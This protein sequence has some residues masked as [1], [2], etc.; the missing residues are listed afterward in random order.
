MFVY[1]SSHNR[2]FEAENLSQMTGRGNADMWL[3]PE[4][5]VQT[6]K[7]AR[8]ALEAAAEGT[9]KVVENSVAT[10]NPSRACVPLP[11]LSPVYGQEAECCEV[12]VQSL[13]AN[14]FVNV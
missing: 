8:V 12:D 4:L 1:L 11:L 7:L 5:V 14:S 3:V 13:V 2:C 10:E 6:G 9:K